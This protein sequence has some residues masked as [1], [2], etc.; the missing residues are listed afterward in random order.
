[1]KDGAGAAKQP[2]TAQDHSE[3]RVDTAAD[4][5]AQWQIL[6][7]SRAPELAMLAAAHKEGTEQLAHQLAQVV[8]K[9]F[10]N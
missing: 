5:Q 1:M 9:R 7:S 4:R 2:S 8:Q 3:E 10:P 6:K